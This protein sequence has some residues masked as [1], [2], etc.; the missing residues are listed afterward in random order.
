MQKVTIRA[1]KL[2]GDEGKYNYFTCNPDENKEHMYVGFLTKGNNPNDLCMPC[3]FKKDQLTSGNKFK[4]SYYKKCIGEKIVLDEKV[5]DGSTVG[6]KIYILQET[7]K[8]Q[9]N[10]FIY[11][12]KYLDLFLIK[13]GKTIIKLKIIIY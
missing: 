11:L 3:C 9:D 7:N 13:F 8:V 10:R 4:M 5:I 1:I 2:L 12:P 6:D